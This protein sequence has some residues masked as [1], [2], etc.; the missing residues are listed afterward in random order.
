MTPA[1][2]D[3]DRELPPEE[4]RRMIRG[5][6]ARAGVPAGRPGATP[7]VSAATRPRV[8]IRD[9]DPADPRLAEVLAELD[10]KRGEAQGHPVDAQVVAQGGET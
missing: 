5:M 1:G 7:P 4:V 6:I 3:D 8:A 10:A 2:P 9:Y